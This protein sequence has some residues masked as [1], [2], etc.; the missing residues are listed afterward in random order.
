MALI[1]RESLLSLETYS[2]EREAFR[3]RVMAHKKNRT[4]HLGAHVTLLFEDE[5]TMRYQ[6][7]EML[8]AERI[9]EDEGIRDELDAYN[10]LVPD[11]DNWKATMLIEYPDEQE[12]RLMLSKLI[13]IEDRVWVQVSGKPRVFAAADED[14]ERENDTKTSSVHFL[15]FQLAPDMIAAVKD[16]AAI[17]VGI[18]HPEY[19]VPGD[20]LA[21]EVAAALARD[22]TR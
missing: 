10:P 2:R 1:T 19:R 3:A 8:R 5:L 20:A 9:F 7:Q 14:L 11:G 15:R 6:V 22:L 17:S 13:G 4:V 18:D 16:G 21:P 12:R